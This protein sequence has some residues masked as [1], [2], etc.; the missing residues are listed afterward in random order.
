MY[1]MAGIYREKTDAQRVAVE[2]RVGEGSQQF[3]SWSRDV[4]RV[5]LVIGSDDVVGLSKNPD[6]PTLDNI[7]R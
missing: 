3:R 2:G 1:T 4:V 5:W 6:G 7:D